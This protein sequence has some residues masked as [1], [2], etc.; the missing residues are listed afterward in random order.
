MARCIPGG[1]LL[2]PPLSPVQTREGTPPRRCDTRDDSPDKRYC[3]SALLRS[4]RH[5]WTPDRWV[6][7]LSY[8]PRAYAPW[9]NRLGTSKRPKAADFTRPVKTVTFKRKGFRSRPLQGLSAHKYVQKANIARAETAAV[10]AQAVSPQKASEVTVHAPDLAS[11]RVT[12]ASGPPAVQTETSFVQPPSSAIQQLN[13]EELSFLDDASPVTPARRARRVHFASEPVWN[14][15]G[16]PFPTKVKEYIKGESMYAKVPPKLPDS[17]M[18]VRD[19]PQPPSPLNSVAGTPIKSNDDSPQHQAYS[20]DPPRT[21]SPIR[22]LKV[23]FDEF[24]VSESSA[25]KK[26]EQEEKLK[27]KE[28]AK[29]EAARKERERE[30]KA[31]HEALLREQKKKDEEERE[32]KREARQK[33]EAEK[34][35]KAKQRK[36][37]LKKLSIVK[38]LTPE[39]DSKVDETMAIKN[40]MAPVTPS[41][42]TRLTRKDLGTLLPQS[43]VDGL[44]GYGWLNDEIVNAYLAAVNAKRLEKTGYTKK[45]DQIPKTHVFGTHLYSTFKD[46][47]FRAVERWPIRAKIGGSRFLS[48]DTILIPL[49]LGDHWTLL[50]ISGTKRTIEYYN[51]LPGVS[52]P[53]TDFA[54]EFLRGTL[55]DAFVEDEWSVIQTRSL[56]QLNGVD[57]GVYVCMNGTALL[58]GI[59][60][61]EAFDPAEIPT[62]RRMVAAT[63]LGKAV[64]L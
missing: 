3:I 46:K 14:P 16:K 37:P 10:S 41:G 44:R 30:Q 7:Y 63:L 13:M 56:Q 49:N 43:K 18:V 17:F 45:S 31:K 29:K 55:G 32:R 15:N 48:V 9:K 20:G 27:A 8:G 12:I 60:P 53:Y 19:I 62:A 61:L 36:E 1:Y 21:P 5:R 40:V 6:P 33:E 11:T 4:L 24:T 34:E 22:N 58:K 35:A 59:D 51:S 50:N 38:G 23:K 39:W 28:E 47:G 54:L 64:E 57:C 52:K 2:S 26:R 42:A 25:T